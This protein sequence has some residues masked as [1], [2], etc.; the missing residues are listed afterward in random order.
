MS[1]RANP[2][3]PESR[4]SVAA[5]RGLATGVAIGAL[6]LAAGCAG[7]PR[8]VNGAPPTARLAPN[9]IPPAP[10]TPEA[11]KKLD[12]LNQQVLREQDAAIAREQQAEAYAR[13]AYAYPNTSWNLYYGGWGGG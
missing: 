11:R 4:T 12:A 1:A 5:L 2:S 3:L 13:A 10:L 9:A 6:L 8:D 7:M